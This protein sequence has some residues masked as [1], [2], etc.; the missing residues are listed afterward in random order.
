MILDYGIIVVYLA[1]ILC[2]GIWSGKG[3][4]SLQ[5]F[6][7][8]HRSY[9]SLVIFAT[10]S[11]S[12]I[13][14]GFSIG[15]AEKVF[16]IG[17]VNIAALWGFSLKEILVARFIAP[18]TGNFPDIISVGDLI[19]RGYGKAA[20]IVAGFFS[21]FLCAGI[22]GAQVKG[23]GVIFN[24]FLGMDPLWGILIGCGIVI[25][26][27][28]AGGMRAVVLTDVIQFCVLAV[29]IPAALAFGVVKAGGVSAIKA[30]VPAGH[31]SIPGDAMPLA[32]FVSL[33]LTFMLG[34]A[35]VP[36]Y[37]QRLFIGRDAGHTARGT[38]LSG[39]FSI[40]FFAIAGA[41]GLVAL[42]LD[43]QLDP[44]LAMPYVVRTVLPVGVRGLVIAGV[45]SI[46]MSS[47]DSFLNGAATCCINDI[48]KP[49][50]R[51]PLPEHRELILA[52][53]TNCLVGILAVV[54]AIRISSVL[55]ILIY[56]YNFWA[57]VIV[58]PLAAVLLG[59]RV[60]RAGFAA[61]TIVGIAGVLIWNRLLDAPAGV[62]GLAI[63]V[64]CNLLA[65]VIAN[66]LSLRAAQPPKDCR[67]R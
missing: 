15:N 41:I 47:A 32:G 44:N 52:K 59:A 35:L 42:A 45:I 22:V 5:E 58:V 62:E 36:P 31:L 26:Y 25:A 19:D 4:K 46:V 43:P 39:V 9:S 16:R 14:G 6:S 13:G 33:F 27:S 60:R 34:E 67:V 20:R 12:F 61:G 65:F 2:V 38:M 21:V 28:T 53:V 40:P 50:R 64:L 66:R 49:L 10:L 54:F 48:V 17:I 29:G 11:A 8:S 30:A 7:V 18:R 23:M 1:V 55:D 56:A 24:V 57:P 51:N 3:M 37:V 63:G